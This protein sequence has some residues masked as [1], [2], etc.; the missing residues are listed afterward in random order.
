MR[1][2][3]E[4]EWNLEAIQEKVQ[5]LKKEVEAMKPDIGNNEEGKHGRKGKMSTAMKKAVQVKGLQNA[6]KV[7]VKN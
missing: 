3:Q 1:T 5:R 6:V 4:D 2:N 7:G